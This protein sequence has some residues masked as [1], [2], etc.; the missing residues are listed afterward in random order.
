MGSLTGPFSALLFH[1]FLFLFFLPFLLLFTLI[2]ISVIEAFLA[3]TA[4]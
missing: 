3:T 1:G 2:V 4:V